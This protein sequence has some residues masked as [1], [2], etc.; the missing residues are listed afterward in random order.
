MKKGTIDEGV[1]F[2]AGFPNA[3]EDQAPHP[4][5]LDA[6]VFLHRASTFVWRL[7]EAVPELGWQIGSVVVVD[8]ALEPRQNDLV[9]AVI[10]ERFVVRK[11][12]QQ[13]LYD[14][15][16]V[17]DEA[18]TAVVWGVITHALQEYRT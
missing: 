2:H 4:L 5:S 11:L 18:A 3:G 9:V 6:M 14:L 17:Q 13:H 15:R 12:H 8:R 16:G 1:V 7:E 10:E